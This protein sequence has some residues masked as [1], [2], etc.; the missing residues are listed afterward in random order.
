MDY[1][2]VDT[3]NYY[4]LEQVPPPMYLGIEGEVC[5]TRKDC[6]YGLYCNNGTCG[7]WIPPQST[8]SVKE[9]FQGVPG[10]EY[11]KLSPDYDDFPIRTKPSK[12]LKYTSRV[13]SNSGKNYWH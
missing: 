6:H 8:Q 12:E 13:H 2:V 10:E 7:Q 1:K 4:T 5:N 9:K 11:Y 3:T